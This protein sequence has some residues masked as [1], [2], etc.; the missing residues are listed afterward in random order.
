LECWTALESH[1]IKP[2][3]IIEEEDEDEATKRQI[4]L[5]KS[6][7]RPRPSSKKRSMR[8]KKVMPR[9]MTTMVLIQ[10]KSTTTKA[11]KK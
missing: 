7:D 6:A 2:Y 11:T 10:T 9:N 1:G 5:K 8:H 4:D 3:R